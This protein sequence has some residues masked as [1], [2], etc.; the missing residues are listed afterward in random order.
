M[1]SPTDCEAEGEA[2]LAAE[3][4][5]E[6]RVPHYAAESLRSS[7]ACRQ[8]LTSSMQRLCLPLRLL[9]TLLW[10]QCSA[11]WTALPK[12][13]RHGGVQS[14]LLRAS[15]PAGASPRPSSHRSQH[16]TND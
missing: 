15:V 3:R 6:R 13:Q 7:L 1:S 5:L 10:V 9:R 2:I 4:E 11:P 12:P 8:T 14:N 16:A